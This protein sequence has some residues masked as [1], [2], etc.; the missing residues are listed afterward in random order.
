MSHRVDII[1]G[2][3]FNDLAPQR[4][5]SGH[6]VPIFRIAISVLDKCQIVKQKMNT[7]LLPANI[8]RDV[9]P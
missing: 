8:T 9:S 2:T 3:Y 6:S 5:K 7:A 4:E 1:L